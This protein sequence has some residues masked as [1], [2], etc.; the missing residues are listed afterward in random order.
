MIFEV[1]W[2]VC[3][4]FGLCY[5]IYCLVVVVGDLCIGEMD[6]IDGFYYLFGVL[7]KL[8]V[9]LLFILMLLLDIGCI[10]IVLVDYVVD[11]LVV[12]MYVDG[13]DG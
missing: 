6:M 10:N 4:M 1:E 7:V 13:W 8:V 9:L 5:C 2:L 11:V 12:F 3:F